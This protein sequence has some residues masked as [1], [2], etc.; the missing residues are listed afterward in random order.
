MTGRSKEGL[1]LFVFI[2]MCFISQSLG[3][4]VSKVAV[5]D[6]T[7]TFESS[8]EGK[9]A[10]TQLKDKEQQIRTELFNLDTE[11]QALEKKLD[12][13]KFT[14]SLES[15]QK[16]AF[17]ID[18]LKIKYKRYEEDS[19]QEYRQLHFRLYNKFRAEVMPIIESL[20]KEK[21]FTIV[22]DLSTVGAAYV[23]PDFDITQEVIKR[24][25]ASKPPKK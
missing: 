4:Q 3:Q 10:L 12:T 2:M 16:I 20:A 23:H 22:F 11:I 21:G 6:S 18:N 5:I 15:Q 8:V 1:V 24:Y 19:A 25:N 17:D 14:L 7:K 13:Q 9:K